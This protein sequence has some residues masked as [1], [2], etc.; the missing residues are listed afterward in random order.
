MGLS[1][2]EANLNHALLVFYQKTHCFSTE[3]PHLSQ[4]GDTEVALECDVLFRH[5]L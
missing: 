1:S 4:F 3:I 2:S 5:G